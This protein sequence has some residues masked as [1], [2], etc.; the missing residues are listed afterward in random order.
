M[1]ELA[2]LLDDTL[3]LDGVLVSVD[4]V[5]DTDSGATAAPRPG[6]KALLNLLATHHRPWAYV[7]TGAPADA[8]LD[9]WTA[10]LPPARVLAVPADVALPIGIR[11][12]ARQLGL[13]PRRAAAVLRPGAFASAA[14][15]VGFVPV[16]LPAPRNRSSRPRRSWR[17]VVAT[18]ASEWQL[19]GCEPPTCRCVPW[20]P[21]PTPPR[22]DARPAAAVRVSRVPAGVF[23][24]SR[25]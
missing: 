13:Q 4:A 10:G 12:A 6:A 23:F 25:V 14:V 19:K 1:F 21:P 22:P 15:L 11:L 2:D 17:E 5:V 3:A 7:T 8:A 24:F 16:T 18:T 9:V 20:K